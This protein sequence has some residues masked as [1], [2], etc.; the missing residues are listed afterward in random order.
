LWRRGQHFVE[1]SGSNSLYRQLSAVKIGMR[2]KAAVGVFDE[3][4]QNA[5]AALDQTLAE[6]PRG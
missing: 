6:L 2:R 1:F 4:Y 3:L 5:P